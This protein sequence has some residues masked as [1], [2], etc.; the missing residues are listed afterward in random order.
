MR[1]QQTFSLLLLAALVSMPALSQEPPKAPPGQMMRP[2]F[3]ERLNLSKEQKSQIEKLRADFQKQQIAQ[4]AKIQ[5][6]AVE[7]RQLLRAENPDKAAIE[8]KINELA[9]LRAQ[10]STARVNQMLNVRKILTPEQQ[11]MIREAVKERVRGRFMERQHRMREFGPRFRGRFEG[12]MGGFW[13]GMRRP[14]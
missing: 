12:R 10:L 6:A 13:P 9:Q 3:M 2:R 1:R 5:T 11:Q 14:F 7:L 8:K 4:R